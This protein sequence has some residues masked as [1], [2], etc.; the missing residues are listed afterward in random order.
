MSTAALCFASERKTCHE[1]QL[2]KKL[3]RFQ[4]QVLPRRPAVKKMDQCYEGWIGQDA[5]TL[6]Y[7]H[8]TTLNYIIEWRNEMWVEEQTLTDQQAQ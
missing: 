4:V 6:K 7:R 5:D 8:S 2:P 1:I 3:R